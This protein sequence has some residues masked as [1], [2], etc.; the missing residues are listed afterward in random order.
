MGDNSRPDITD[1][2]VNFVLNDPLMPISVIDNFL[3]LAVILRTGKPAFV[4]SKKAV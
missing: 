3:L 4:Q 2:I 1:V